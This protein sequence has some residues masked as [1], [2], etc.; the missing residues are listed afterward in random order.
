M[1]ILYIYIYIYIYVYFI[2]IYI[3]IHNPT[4]KDT[5]PKRVRLFA[6]PKDVLLFAQPKTRHRHDIVAMSCLGLCEEKYV[7]GLCEQTKRALRS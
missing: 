1:C 3:Y 2:N 6:Q 5:Q 4:I 7:L